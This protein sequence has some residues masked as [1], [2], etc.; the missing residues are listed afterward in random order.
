MVIL[1][2]TGPDKTTTALEMLFRLMSIDCTFISMPP[3]CR[4]HFGTF[5]DRKE[6]VT[7]VS[8]PP[9]FTASLTLLRFI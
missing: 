9:N 8:E 7:V 3:Q 6:I 5:T 1:S 2:A 4:V